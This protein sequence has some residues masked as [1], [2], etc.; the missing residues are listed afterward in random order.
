MRKISLFIV[1]L[2]PF[3]ISG[4]TPQTISDTV[5][6]FSNN[7]L[8]EYEILMD[9]DDDLD[10][11]T[12]QD[13]I[14]NQ[15]D[16]PLSPEDCFEQE[17]YDP[18]TQSCVLFC[19]TDAECDALEDEIQQALDNLSEEIY[20]ETQA[21]IT[22]ES[23]QP[24]VGDTQTEIDSEIDELI[25]YRISGNQLKEIQQK[26][27]PAENEAVLI[28]QYEKH[29]RMLEYFNQLFP[30]D[31]RSYVSYFAIFTDGPGNTYGAVHQSEDNPRQ[32]VLSM[33]IVDAFNGDD[34]NARELTYT[35]VHEFGH[36]LTLNETQIDVD[37]GIYYIESGQTFEEIYEE[38]KALCAP[39]V[40]IEEGC[41]NTGSTINLFYQ[42]FW[43][44]IKDEHDLIQEIEDE[45]EYQRALDDFYEKNK[46]QFV[47][48]YAAT[49]L[50]EDIAESFTAFVLKDKPA[51]ATT[52]A[53]QKILFFYEIEYLVR[54][55][56][57]IRTSIARQ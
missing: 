30:A 1:F 55:R 32:W 29:R 6:Y 57:N 5:S 24:P 17:T 22:P 50:G 3:V 13:L 52:I 8:S 19:S 21:Q 28:G 43:K 25:R 7:E 46:N 11:Q 44:T 53:D 23:P 9:P 48:Q 45:N 37:S 51:E 49:N 27:S 4:C 42:Q 26:E 54:L 15:S 18:R 40:F 20:D 41:S 16:T 47:T 12:E 39:Q 33:D 31:L 14:V 56:E 10:T 38:K 35:L 36:I 2:L 34:F